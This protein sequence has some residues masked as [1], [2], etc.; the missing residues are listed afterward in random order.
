[1]KEG[2]WDDCSLAI[3]AVQLIWA[4]ISGWGVLDFF[5]YWKVFW[6]VR[7]CL[8]GTAC[9]RSTLIRRN[10]WP[11]KQR[12]YYTFLV[13]IELSIFNW[14]TDS[15]YAWN[16][17]VC[18]AWVDKRNFLL[19]LVCNPKKGKSNQVQWRKTLP[20]DKK[21]NA[22]FV[23]MWHSH[24]PLRCVVE[25]KAVLI[26]K[27]FLIF[28][29]SEREIPEGCLVFCICEFFDLIAFLR[30]QRSSSSIA[31]SLPVP[32]YFRVLGIL[33]TWLGIHSSLEKWLI[34]C[35]RAPQHVRKTWVSFWRAQP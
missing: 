10:Q 19:S 23:I 27:Y 20:S 8:F 35:S 3:R 22:A 25:I 31:N 18:S 30:I 32:M 21:K 17:I 34:A 9:A 24:N 6:T 14:S 11:A 13:F 26:L 28:S 29:V 4:R 33:S 2:I 16:V 5:L 1:M 15:T 7:H 12:V